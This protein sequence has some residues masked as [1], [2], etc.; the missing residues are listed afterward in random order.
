M[1]ALH[2][3][4]GGF[5]IIAA[6]LVLYPHAAAAQVRSNPVKAATPSTEAFPGDRLFHGP[7][8]TVTII[9]S[10]SC[11]HCAKFDRIM[12]I[13]ARDLKAAGYGLVYQTMSLDGG[14][15]ILNAMTS[16][17]DGARYIPRVRRLF[18]NQAMMQGMSLEQKRAHLVRLA[19]SLGTTPDAV[20]RCTSDAAI[21]AGIAAEEKALDRYDAKGTPSVYLNGRLVGYG[22]GAVGRLLGVPGAKS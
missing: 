16:C 3:F 5:A 13:V 20:R 10:Y 11:P 2:R 15:A 12:P 6:G 8:G 21:K 17:R 19:T 14:D 4:F 22:P 18:A 1:I 9:S 7:K